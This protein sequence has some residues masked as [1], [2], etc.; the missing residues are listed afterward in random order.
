MLEQQENLFSAHSAFI[1][2]IRYSTMALFNQWLWITFPMDKYFSGVDKQVAGGSEFA[3]VGIM[4][5][6][7][8]RQFKH[9]CH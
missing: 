5:G 6:A 2:L 1:Q 7:K 9:P 3:I 4:P 8:Q